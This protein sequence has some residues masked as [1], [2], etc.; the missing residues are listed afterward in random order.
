MIFPTPLLTVFVFTVQ[1]AS[2][3]IEAEGMFEILAAV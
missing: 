2:V 1:A 3:K